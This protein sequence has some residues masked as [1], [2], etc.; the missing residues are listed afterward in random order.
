[1]SGPEDDPRD[2]MP[3][4]REEWE[5][6]MVE[7]EAAPAPQ[8]ATLDKIKQTAQRISTLQHMGFERN[9]A[10]H[11]HRIEAILREEFGVSQAEAP[12]PSAPNTCLFCSQVLS[13]GPAQLWCM[14][15]LCSAQ[16]QPIR[17]V[18]ESRP[19][20]PDLAREIGNLIDRYDMLP[21]D[22]AGDMRE[23]FSAFT[24]AIEKLRRV[25]ESRP[26]EEVERMAREWMEHDGFNPETVEIWKGDL[27][28]FYWYMV[29]QQ[30][31]QE[32]R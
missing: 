1:M 22:F 14:N 26:A 25:A 23:Q 18:A 3:I 6:A 10:L 27:A 20:G 12:L 17:R 30:A 8:A 21:N 11:T 13:V 31:K 32:G 4:D 5:A 16:F 9:L 24:G 2:D 29:A 15:P 28:R 7:G 19:S